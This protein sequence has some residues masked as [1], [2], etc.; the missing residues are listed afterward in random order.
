[1]RK[2]DQLGETIDIEICN[3]TAWEAVHQRFLA[4]LVF[5]VKLPLPPHALGS[6]SSRTNA[7]LL[8]VCMLQASTTAAMI[9]E[10]KRNWKNRLCLDSV[11]GSSAPWSFVCVD[12]PCRVGAVYLSFLCALQLTALS[13]QIVCAILWAERDGDLELTVQRFGFV[14]L[15]LFEAECTFLAIQRW[16]IVFQI[17]YI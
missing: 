4:V 13:C 5:S 14:F 3:C 17:Q 9:R 15:D 7:L 12:L 8:L 6:A 11:D 2:N 16:K 10:C 1:M